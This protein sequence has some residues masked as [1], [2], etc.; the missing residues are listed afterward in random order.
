MSEDGT[1]SVINQ[2]SFSQRNTRCIDFSSVR[3]CCGL[4]SFAYG[5]KVRRIPLHIWVAHAGCAIC[6]I[7][8]SWTF[9]AGALHAPWCGTVMCCK[10]TTW[11]SQFRLI[12]GLR[13]LSSIMY[14][15]LCLSHIHWDWRN[16]FMYRKLNLTY[17]GSK[18]IENKETRICRLM[19][20]FDLC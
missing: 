3:A 18:T 19:R 14:S 20:L 13:I 6:I 8:R 7:M 5:F 16:C 2:S 12:E 11:K 1:G 9:Y 17:M 15:H 4:T 10:A